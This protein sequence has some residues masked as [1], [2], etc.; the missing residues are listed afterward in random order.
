MKY[1]TASGTKIAN[2]GEKSNTMMTN[3]NDIVGT[4]WQTVDVN[5][6]LPS[7][8]QI[9]QQGRRVIFGAHGGVMQNVSTGHETHSAIENDTYVLDLWIP[10]GEGFVGQ[11]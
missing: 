8:R 6:P 2:K 4:T 1:I 11:G 3:E 5:R 9:C 10:P 7:V